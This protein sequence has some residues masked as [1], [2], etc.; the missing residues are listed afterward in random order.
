MD[1]VH[2]LRPHQ[3]RHVAGV[4]RR[5]EMIGVDAGTDVSE[6]RQVLHQVVEIEWFQRLCHGILPHAYCSPRIDEQH[7]VGA[8]GEWRIVCF[9]LVVRHRLREF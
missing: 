9:L 3:R 1:D 8:C 5:V 6:F 7:L 2:Q 4:D